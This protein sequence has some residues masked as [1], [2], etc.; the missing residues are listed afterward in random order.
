MQKLTLKLVNEDV[1]YGGILETFGDFI[2]RPN[3]TALTEEN[4]DSCMSTLLEVVKNADYYAFS[5][6][7]RKRIITVECKILDRNTVTFIVKD[8]GAGFDPEEMKKGKG[9][10]FLEEKCTSY[11]IDSTYKGTTVTFTK[12]V[13]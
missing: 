1:H 13:G 8:N 11:D 10:T 7:M 3:L 4:V 2:S 5:G 6:V 12:K 9:L